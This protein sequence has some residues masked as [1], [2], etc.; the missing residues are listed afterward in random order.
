MI[1]IDNNFLSL[2][3]KD[4]SYSSLKLKAQSLSLSLSEIDQIKCYVEIHQ[5]WKKSHTCI[6]FL[7]FWWPNRFV[8][9]IGVIQIYILEMRQDRKNAEALA[10]HM[11]HRMQEPTSSSI[12]R[13]FQPVSKKIAIEIKPAFKYHVKHSIT[14]LQS[15]KFVSSSCPLLSPFQQ[16]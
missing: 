4:I 2:F 8:L 1:Y 3:L 5:F 9:R 14:K 11:V 15:T 13:F 10:T 7:N 6:R 12:M 16:M